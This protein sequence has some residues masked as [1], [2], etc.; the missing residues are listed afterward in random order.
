M[1]YFFGMIYAVLLSFSAQTQVQPSILFLPSVNLNKK[2]EKDW[3]LNFK[4]ESRQQ[5]YS[6]K[7]AYEYLFTDFAVAGGKK[8]A[9]NTRIVGGYL[10]RLEPEDVAHRAMQQLIIVS[11][12]GRFRCAH[13]IASDQTFRQQNTPEFRLR[14]RLSSELPLNGATLDPQ[15]LYLKLSNE[16]LGSVQES[17]SDLEIR[18]LGFMGYTLT[19]K[20]KLEIGL[21]Y[22]LDQFFNTPLRNRY[23]V[24]INYYLSF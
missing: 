8:I 10:F 2:L 9:A 21:D 7:T 1:R 23:F 4:I 11:K 6:G 5:V 17:Q 13:R 15:E 20:S 18:G 3:S 14:Y 19:D 22:R 16:Y 12:Y 24:G